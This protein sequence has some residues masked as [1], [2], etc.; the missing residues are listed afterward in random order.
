MTG[1]WCLWLRGCGL[2][3]ESGERSL[4]PGNNENTTVSVKTVGQ[5]GIRA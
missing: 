5:C 3:N 4:A 1:M 2:D